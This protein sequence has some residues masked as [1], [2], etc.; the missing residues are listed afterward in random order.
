MNW[1]QPICGDC[2][3]VRSPGRNPTCMS[4][5]DA[6]VCCDCGKTTSEGIFLG[7]DP[8]TVPFPEDEE[9]STRIEEG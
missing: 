9:E 7:V 1:T 5:P 6:R 3:A 4:D 2:Y 8:R